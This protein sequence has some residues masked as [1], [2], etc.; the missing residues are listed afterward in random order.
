V[1]VRTIGS[2]V[3]RCVAAG[4]VGVVGASIGAAAGWGTAHAEPAQR[5]VVLRAS[6]QGVRVVY[7][8]PDYVV[9]SQ[10][11][12]GGG[13]VTQAEADSTGRATSFASLP[14]P[15]ENAIAGPG[16]L[17]VALGQSVPLAYPFYVRADNPTSPSAELKDPSGTYALTASAADGAARA[18]GLLQ[19]M[20]GVSGTRST[21]TTVLDD[22]GVVRAVAE[23][24]STGIS[25]GDGALRI[26]SV[27]TRSETTLGPDDAKPQTA[28]SLL[29]EGASVG[30]HPVTID[31]NGVH[32]EKQTVPAP[33]GQGFSTENQLLGQAGISVR[34]VPAGVSG[35][36]DALVIT[37]G[38]TFPA[39]GNP[40]GTVVMTFGG[41]V[42]EI[43]VGSPEGVPVETAL[44]AGPAAEP[45]PGTTVAAPGPPVVA[46]LPPSVSAATL[47]RA[48]A[49]ADQLPRLTGA[50]DAAAGAELSAPAT[51][52]EIAVGVHGVPVQGV[53]GVR[54]EPDLGTTGALYA[55]LGIG[56]VA[57]VGATRL[58]RWRGAR[59]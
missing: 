11:F 27:T 59:P 42:S 51:G 15:G 20:S 55:L 29:I 5:S 31:A 16:V 47:E 54:V 4:V 18:T 17:S 50:A 48:S 22:Q 44:P 2:A 28:S 41:S 32:A 46:P 3:Q 53:A 34:V 37:S 56:G 21:T 45:G 10:L 36:A 25:V 58:L 12:D 19:G 7:T 30:G 8:V 52:S 40:K 13:P 9:V 33:V 23:S 38:Q 26:A 6:A 57:L 1:T 35:G 39:P 24:I 14:Y 49:I 43:T